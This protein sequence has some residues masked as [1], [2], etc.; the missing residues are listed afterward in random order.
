MV[1]DYYERAEL[2]PYLDV[3]GF[4]LIGYGCTTCIGNSG[5]LV[6]EVAAAVDEHDLTVVSVLSGNCNFE[7][8]IHPQVKM[9]YLMLSPLVVA[10]VIAGTMNIDLQKAVLGQNQQGQDVHLKDI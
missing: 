7:G 1:T 3:L 4:S 2:T 9:N 10:Y 5:P 6:P 8:R